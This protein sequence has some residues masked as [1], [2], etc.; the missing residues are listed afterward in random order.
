ML[1]E[2]TLTEILFRTHVIPTYTSHD[3]FDI[4]FIF[5]AHTHGRTD[6][7]LRDYWYTKIFYTFAML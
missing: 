6:M 2:K 5:D 3:N 4:N 7:R 1:T